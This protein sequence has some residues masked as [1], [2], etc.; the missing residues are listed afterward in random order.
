MANGEVLYLQ[1]RR[2][3]LM[4]EY[5]AL[6][7]ETIDSISESD[8]IAT[9]IRNMRAN[10]LSGDVTEQDLEDYASLVPVLTYKAKVMKEEHHKR[11]SRLD[12]IT[13]EVVYIDRLCEG[14]DEE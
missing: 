7:D 11:E 10:V 8:K 12:E 9:M 6:L 2:K 3:N 5:K 4:D 13:K 14:E 1:T